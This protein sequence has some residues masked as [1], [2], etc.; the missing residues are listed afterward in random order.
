[1]A[2]VETSSE[3]FAKQLAITN[4]IDS[5]LKTIEDETGL[6]SFSNPI[7]KHQPCLER[8]NPVKTFNDTLK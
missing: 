2:R 1:M 6:Y 4:V 5:H 8:G 7:L 3:N